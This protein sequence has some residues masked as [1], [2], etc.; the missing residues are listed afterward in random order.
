MLTTKAAKAARIATRAVAGSKKTLDNT[1]IFYNR[2]IRPRVSTIKN[3]TVEKSKEYAHNAKPFY[4]QNIEPKV[5]KIKRTIAT[6]YSKYKKELKNS[7]GIQ[8]ASELLPKKYS[9]LFVT[10]MPPISHIAKKAVEERKNFNRQKFKTEVVNELKATAITEAT[11]RCAKNTIRKLPPLQQIAIT[12]AV[13]STS[14]YLINNEHIKKVA[15]RTKE[16]FKERTNKIKKTVSN[17]KIG[18]CH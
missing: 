5:P 18:R 14:D 17:T 9:D 6:E 8:A 4:Q 2:N 15:S 10:A 13:G 7:F 1:T 16:T 11:L 12:T 3:A